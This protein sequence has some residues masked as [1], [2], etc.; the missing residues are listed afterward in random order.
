L[1]AKVTDFGYSC[2]GATGDDIVLLPKTERWCAP[3][4]HPRHFTIRDAKKTDIYSFGMICA[5][6]FSEDFAK[7]RDELA[8]TEAVQQGAKVEARQQFQ[9]SVMHLASKTDHLDSSGREKLAQFFE[10]ALCEN[11][12][13]RKDELK[14]LILLFGQACKL[15][16]PT[17]MKLLILNNEAENQ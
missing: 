16:N 4:W 3:E 11:N 2:F 8:V 9:R 17:E 6:L 1:I 5:W 7:L 10:Y 15:S 14:D 13:A 12:Q